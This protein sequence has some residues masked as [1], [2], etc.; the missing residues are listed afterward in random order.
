MLSVVGYETKNAD[1]CVGGV[2]PFSLDRSYRL[3]WESEREALTVENLQEVYE[4]LKPIRHGESSIK[5]LKEDAEN[6]VRKSRGM[7]DI[8]MIKL[9]A[10]EY[11]EKTMSSRIVL[12]RERD[13]KKEMLFLRN[14]NMLDKTYCERLLNKFKRIKKSGLGV[15]LTVKSMEITSVKGD[16]KRIEKCFQKLMWRIK[17]RYPKLK[18]EYFRVC[19]IGR[20]NY[21]VHYHLI[22]YGVKYIKQKWLSEVWKEITGDSYV[23]W[24]SRRNRKA[25]DYAMKYITKMIREGNAEEGYLI[26]WASGLRVWSCSRG[27]FDMEEEKETGGG[28]VLLG[29]CLC[30][31]YEGLY[32]V[33]WDPG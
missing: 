8:E 15:T 32:V 13:G 2:E 33:E 30:D 21:T 20:R 5:R 11:R 19:E 29:L 10:R 4:S 16:I 23:V 1:G 7:M 18:I 9:C 14:V 28:W 17:Y 3:I 12:E 24:V 31:K 27:L 26:L 25:V 6:E 22:F